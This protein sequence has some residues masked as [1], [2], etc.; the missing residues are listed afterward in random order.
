MSNTIDINLGDNN[1]M[2]SLSFYWIAEFEDNCIYQFENGIEHR[3]QEVKNKINKLKYFT[4]QHKEKTIN[5]TVDLTLGIITF[6]KNY[7]AGELKEEKQNIRLIFFRRHRI[8]M[9]ENLIKKSHI[10]EYHLGF[11]YNDKN[12]NNQKIILQI[13]EQGNWILGE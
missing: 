8:T 4:L 12:G 7:Q 1:S 13:D 9:T 5:F 2:K 3:F 6:N 10:I 11:Q